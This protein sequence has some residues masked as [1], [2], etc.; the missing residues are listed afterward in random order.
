MA[1]GGTDYTDHFKDVFKDLIGHESQQR[2]SVLEQTCMVEMMEGQN[3][4]FDK[5]GETA[6]VTKSSRAEVKT[7]SD[8]TYER[9][10]VTESFHTFDHILD[11]EDLIKYVSNPQNAIVLSAAYSL[12][13]QKDATI[14]TAISGSATVV[15]NGTPASVALPAG[16]KIAAGAA[17]LTVAKLREALTIINTAHAVTP[18]Q[19]VYCAGSYAQIMQLSTEAQTVSSDF[20]ILKPLEGPGIVQGL[21]GFLGID[22]VQYEDFA[23][24]TA[25][26]AVYL[27]TDDAIQLGIFA[28]LTV[29]IAKDTTRIGNPDGIAVW[30]ST[31]ASRI[32]EEKV[33]EIACIVVP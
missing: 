32:W 4:F 21:S 23:D 18:G 16:Q 11:S 10:Q 29:E 1:L 33:V 13:R 5:L 3:V 22:F 31:G 17:T 2:G 19:R 26:Q 7:L 27:Y 15:T 6:T 8:V 28:P 20:R 24:I 25:D 9:R 14:A 12:G 30:E